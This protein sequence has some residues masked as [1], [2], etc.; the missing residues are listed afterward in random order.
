[1]SAGRRVQIV[2]S[3]GVLFG[4]AP[5]DPDGV[6]ELAARL[7]DYAASKVEQQPRPSDDAPTTRV[8][9]VADKYITRDGASPRETGR[10]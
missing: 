5:D 10:E 9:A 7:L 3:N 4:R 8:Q 1:M 2:R 6:R